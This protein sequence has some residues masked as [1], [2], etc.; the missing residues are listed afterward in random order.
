M[1]L[2]ASMLDD[3]ALRARP[4]GFELDIHLT[5]Y[6]SLPLSCVETIELTVNGEPVP[7][8]EI[9]VAVNG[10]EHS[11]DDLRER[12]DDVWFVLD[13]ATLRVRGPI[14]RVG[15]AAEVTVRLANRIPYILIGPRTPLV[16]ATERS[17]TLVAR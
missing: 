11:L 6:R 8:G 15:E 2:A 12:W 17:M 14:L 3:D 10:G 13:P 1:T 5:W 4:Q 7:R 16:Y 9:A